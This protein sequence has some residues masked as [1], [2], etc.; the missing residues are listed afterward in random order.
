MNRE[1]SLSA[2]RLQL[3]HVLLLLK[4]AA[5]VAGMRKL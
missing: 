4:A 1:S 3:L 2:Q 5:S